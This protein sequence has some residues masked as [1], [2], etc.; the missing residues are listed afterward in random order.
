[1]TAYVITD[2]HVSDET[3]YAGYKAL[4]PDAIAAAGGRFLA[5]G[6]SV[7]TLE[8]DWRP[9]RVVVVEFDSLQAARTFYD[10]TLYRQARDAR[11]GATERF[12]MICVEG[13]PQGMKV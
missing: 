10:S 13:L 1:M 4:S 2:I 11:A 7:T 12:N 5:R 9:S 6:G 3:R 8:G